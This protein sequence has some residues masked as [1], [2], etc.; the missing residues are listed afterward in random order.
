MQEEHE[1]WTSIH[2]AFQFLSKYF[3]NS[4][5]GIE[6]GL[7]TEEYK[8]VQRVAEMRRRSSASVQSYEASSSDEF[9]LNGGSRQSRRNSFIQMT[10]IQ[11]AEMNENDEKAQ[12]AQ[13][14]AADIIKSTS[15]ADVFRKKM[16]KGR[17]KSVLDTVTERPLLS[18]DEITKF[19]QRFEHHVDKHHIQ[20]DTFE[21]VGEIFKRTGSHK[22]RSSL[23]QE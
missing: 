15:M 2:E 8:R 4:R 10:G 19:N 9:E 20:D 5:D 7:I 14:V 16:S 3:I 17:R 22:R 1:D 21:R 6:E 12:Q 13:A 11:E 23:R 18:L